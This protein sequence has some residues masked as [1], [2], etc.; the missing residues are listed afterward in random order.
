MCFQ[1][2]VVLKCLKHLEV[3]KED[4]FLRYNDLYFNKDCDLDN[5]YA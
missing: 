1:C 2:A 4:T 5:I 3:L